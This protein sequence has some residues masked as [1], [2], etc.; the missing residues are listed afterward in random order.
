MRSVHGAT[1]IQTRF[2]SIRFVPCTSFVMHSLPLSRPLSLCVSLPLTSPFFNFLNLPFR[3]KQTTQSKYTPLH[4]AVENNASLAVQLLSEGA[5]VMVKTAAPPLL[6]FAAT[7]TYE[8]D[9]LLKVI[10]CLL[11]MMEE[12]MRELAEDSNE[13]RA[14]PIPVNIMAG[15]MSPADFAGATAL[16]VAAR[17]GN[18]SVVRILLSCEGIEPS[19][20][21]SSSKQWPASVPYVSTSALHAASE[22]GHAAVVSL[23]LGDGRIDA[24]CTDE[25]G[26]TAFH[27]AVQH[28]HV[29]V[30]NVFCDAIVEGGISKSVLYAEN[31]DGESPLIVA[32]RRNVS[33]KS[34]VDLAMAQTSGVE[35]D[36]EAEAARSDAIT[37]RLLGLHSWLEGGGKSGEEEQKEGVD[38]AG[39]GEAEGKGGEEQER[40]EEEGA[41]AIDSEGKEE[42]NEEKGEEEKEEQ[43]VALE[44]A[45]ELEAVSSSVDQGIHLHPCFAQGKVYD[46]REDA[47][48]VTASQDEVEE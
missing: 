43:E 40:K 5:S 36:N 15:P 45:E 28:S 32:E 11:A 41:E 44:K 3:Q 13:N 35:W 16:I 48:A 47:G 24:L 20:S 1:T 34:G 30:I 46:P 23:L 8:D 14:M 42:G 27:L 17:K 31:S 9:A 19:R 33:I 37:L 2:V 6:L 12:E 18:T 4:F 21:A 26:E 39:D 38:E 22:N 25:D 7:Q 29:E 10:G